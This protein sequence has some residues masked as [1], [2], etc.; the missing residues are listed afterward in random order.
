MINGSSRSATILFVASFFAFLPSASAR[1]P[2]HWDRFAT[3]I[4]AFHRADALAMPPRCRT[5]FVGSS[6][7]RLWN[8]IDQ[9]FQF[10]I[11]RRGVGG[12]TIGE[13]NHYFA[14]IVAPYKPSRIVFYAGENDL[15]EGM[16]P[17]SVLNDLRRFMELKRRNLGTTPV[18]FLSAKPSPARAGDLEKQRL[19]N[20]AA[21]RLAVQM[22]DLD[23]V[24]VVTPMMGAAGINRELFGPDQLHMNAKGYAIWVEQIETALKRPAKRRA[25]GC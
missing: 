24:D 6:S 17:T 20:A 23:F 13:I 4:E 19:F 14:D 10:P 12:S 7:I 1:E 21:Q 16:K 11:V 25:P 5:L 2:N 22:A 8:D 18:Y 9:A 3:E 15:N